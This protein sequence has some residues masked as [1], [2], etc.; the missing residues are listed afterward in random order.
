[1]ARWLV[2][3]LTAMVDWRPTEGNNEVSEKSDYAQTNDFKWF[4]PIQMLQICECRIIRLS[5]DTLGDHAILA[6]A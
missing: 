5:L 2:A 1:M 3:A 4:I 6:L